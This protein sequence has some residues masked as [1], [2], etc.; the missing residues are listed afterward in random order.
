MTKLDSSAR[1]HRWKVLAIGVAANASFSAAFSGIPTTAIPIRSHYQLSNGVLGLMLG[2]MGLGIALSELPWGLLTDRWG[3]RKV[4]LSGLAATAAMLLW[5]ANFA[6][7]APALPQWRLAFGLLM[8]GLLGGSVNGS[9][10]RAVMAWF[11]DGE[12][13]LAMSIRQTAV[14]FGGMIGAVLLPLLATHF[15]FVAVYLTLAGLCLLSAL[16]TWRWLFEPPETAGRS[17]AGQQRAKAGHSPL[18][19]PAIWRL[20]LAMGMLCAPQIAVLAFGSVFLHDRMHIGLAYAAAGL[21]T[22][23]IG[24]AIARVWSGHWTDRRGNRRAYLRACS[25]VSVALFAALALLALW[26]EST[27]GATML[28][29]DIALVLLVAGGVAASAWHGVAFTEVA[30]QAG[31]ARAGT[32]LGLANTS[33]FLMASATPMAIPLLLAHGAWPT[34]WATAALFALL[35]LPVLPQHKPL[36]RVLVQQR[37]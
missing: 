4:L 22:M 37:G 25:R 19:D 33:V 27:G 13:G 10:G 15:G 32:A 6:V 30:V 35:A 20:V 2:M 21:A 28:L 36:A 18:R 31:A 9:S 17:A 11:R 26:T 7:P 1:G 14:P 12:R 34:V 24:A 8:V 5:M 3:D 23:Q 29:A 16:L